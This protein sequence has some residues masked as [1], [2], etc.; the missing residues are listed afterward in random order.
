M[1]PFLEGYL[2][3]DV[4]QRLASVICELLAP[5]ISP[6]YV[7]RLNLY[8]VLDTSPEEDVGIMYPDVEVMRR[9]LEE[10]D[11]GYLTKEKPPITPATLSIPAIQ[12][13]EVRIP[14]VEIRDR[15]KNQLI[16]AIEVLSP[17]NKRQPGRQLYLEKRRQIL[18]AQVHLLEIDLIRRG[19]RPVQ[20]P[21]L[22]AADYLI[23]LTRV[24][25]G[26][27]D[28]W[29]FSLPESLPVL[30][31]PLKAPDPDAVLDLGEALTISYDRGLYQL[32]VNYQKMPPPPA[33]SEVKMKWMKKV[34][35]KV[36]LK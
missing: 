5:Q 11:E 10:P 36:E 23:T 12:P 2:W 8:T 9:K 25:A 16:T 7:A 20:H 21:D 6:D 18:T 3:P 19:Q 4:H 14:F 35:E 13:V 27:T 15:Q 1:D 26:R 33:I 29:A 34:L 17:V 28:A 24:G 22:V 31:I 32:S 30:P